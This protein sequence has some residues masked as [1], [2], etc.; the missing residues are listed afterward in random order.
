MTATI[1]DNAGRLEIPPEIGQH[2]GLTH[3]SSL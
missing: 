2:M 3:E 1:I